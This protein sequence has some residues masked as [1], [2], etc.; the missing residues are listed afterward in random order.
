VRD[1]F[2]GEL[3][4]GPHRIGWDGADDAGRRVAPGL[5]F[6]RAEHEGVAQAVRVTVLTP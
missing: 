4:A 6:V 1:L 5:Y 2:A 3:A